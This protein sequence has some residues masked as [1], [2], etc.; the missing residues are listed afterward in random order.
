MNETSDTR[1]PWLRRHWL[2]V[3]FFAIGLVAVV[4]VVLAIAMFMAWRAS[5]EKAL[6]DAIQY[7]ADAPGKYTIT[8]NGD[9]MVLTT[10]GQRQSLK[11]TYHD[12]PFEAVV[13]GN[14]LYVKSSTPDKFADMFL[15]KSG[16]LPAVVPVVNQV[17]TSLKD[18]WVSMDTAKLPYIGADT[19]T[20]KCLLSA[21]S[22]LV[23]NRMAKGELADVYAS[24]GFLSMQTKT[25]TATEVT[26]HV[27]IDKKKLD[28]FADKLAATKFYQSLTNEC[29]GFDQVLKNSGA[30]PIG[31]DVTITK[32]DHRLKTVSAGDMRITAQDTQVGTIDV[33]KD[34]V[35]YDSLAM[36][37]TE[38]VFKS[39][40]QRQ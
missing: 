13:N 27:N 26:Y 8:I 5:P 10:D 21:R 15:P 36:T 37:V 7:A 9:T 22:Q 18:R 17:V 33:P 29:A 2:A 23:T 30:K 20:M 38:S 25:T 4:F 28:V 31:A 40:W 16:L 6:A 24:N 11:G 1:T 39:L 19:N 34:V 35:A 12:M 32:S 14:V 3:A